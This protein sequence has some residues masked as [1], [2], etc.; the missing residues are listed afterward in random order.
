MVSRITLSG[1]ESQGMVLMAED[2]DGNLAP[3]S[4]EAMPGSI[5]R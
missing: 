4:A 5:I 3:I 1:L 2:P